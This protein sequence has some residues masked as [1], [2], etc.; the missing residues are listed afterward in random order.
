MV[1]IVA[2]G[3]EAELLPN[4]SEPPIYIPALKTFITFGCAH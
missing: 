3:S 2:A 1:E 4:H